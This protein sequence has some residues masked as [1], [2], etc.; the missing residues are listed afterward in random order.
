LSAGESVSK[1]NPLSSKCTA[2]SKRTGQ[3]CDQWVVGGGVCW[4]HN[5]AQRYVKANREARVVELRAR[6]AGGEWE[7][8][9]PGEALVAAAQDA[10]ALVQRLKTQ[11]GGGTLDAASLLALGNWLDRVGQLSKL[12]LDTP[13]CEVGHDN[14]RD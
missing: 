5:G 8:R 13:S 4:H 2:K 12:V 3:A 7:D 1:S 6:I 10:D 9:D 14:A 11:L